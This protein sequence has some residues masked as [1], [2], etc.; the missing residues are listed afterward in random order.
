MSQNL[1]TVKK[2]IKTI[3]STKKITN[4]M[5]LVSSIKS[6]KLANEFKMNTEF[7]NEL[8]ELFN[9]AIYIDSYKN[10]ANLDSIFL[11]QVNSDKNLYVVIMSNLGLCGSYNSEIFKY[12]RAILNKNDKVLI[13]EAC[14][15]HPTCE[16][17]GRVKLPMLLQKATGKKLDFTFAPGRDY[18]ENIQDFK[19]IVHCGSCMLNRKE[20]L[21]RIE[22]AVKNNVPI[23]NYGMAISWCQGVLDKV[24]IPE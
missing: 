3:S 17:I 22:C 18:P 1:T 2:R 20:T 24:L 5:K 9:N 8:V 21:W 11:N 16:D 7:Y 14:T 19:L 6:R 15:H 23:T 4:S 10:A 12:L 13:A